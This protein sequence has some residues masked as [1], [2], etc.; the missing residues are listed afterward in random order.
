MS[1]DESVE[2]RLDTIES[3]LADL[4]ERVTELETK[5]VPDT[6]SGDKPE[7]REFVESADPDNHVERSL[8]LAAYLEQLEES[9]GFTTNDIS[10][11][12]ERIRQ[13]QPANMSD[14]LAR[15]EQ[16]DYTMELDT[17]G[18][19]KRWQLTGDGEQFVSELRGDER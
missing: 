4:T 8:L 1:E 12:Y 6:V 16:Q 11:G 5:L 13:K 3:K 14:V 17:D 15:A 10:A 9:D 19:G 2:E 7:I 18:R